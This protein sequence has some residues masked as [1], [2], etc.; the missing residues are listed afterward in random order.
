M[1]VFFTRRGKTPPKPALVTITGTGNATYCY[2]TVNGTKYTAAASGIEVMAGDFIGFSICGYSNSYKGQVT[3]DG[4]TVLTATSKTVT[5][6][7]WTVPE[8]VSEIAI[9]ISF[10]SGRNYGTIT[11]TTA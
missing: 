10:T 4:T 6:Y 11:V 5:T 7:A 9:A 2:A 8:G 1:A 3:I